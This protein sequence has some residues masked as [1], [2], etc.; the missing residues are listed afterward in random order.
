MQEFNLRAKIKTKRIVAI[1]SGLMLTLEN[2]VV[3][4]FHMLAVAVLT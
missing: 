1:S 3:A 2:V 4:V